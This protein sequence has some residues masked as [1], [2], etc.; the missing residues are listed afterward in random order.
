[1]WREASGT[2]SE[3]LGQSNGGFEWNPAGALN[4]STAWD[5]VSIG[6]F[7]GDGHDDLI[8]RQDGTGKVMEWLGQQN[9]GFAWNV[10]Y[11]LDTSWH[12]QPDMPSL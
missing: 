9:G 6:D 11:A 12:I 2:L 10:D 7:N 3:W 1:M 5:V 4:V 8:W